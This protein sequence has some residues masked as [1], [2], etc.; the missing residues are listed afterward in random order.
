MSELSLTAKASLM[1]PEESKQEFAPGEL[2]LVSHCPASAT[3]PWIWLL[4]FDNITW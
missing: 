1:R 4:V 2:V 3:D